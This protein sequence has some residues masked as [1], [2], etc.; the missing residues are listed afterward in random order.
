VYSC[1]VIENDIDIIEQLLPAVFQ[2][3]QVDETS[4][5]IVHRPSH[6][7]TTI[8]MNESRRWAPMNRRGVK[9]LIVVNYGRLL[10]MARQ[11]DH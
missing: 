3:R 6:D 2:K 4:R 11:M 5:L 7:P 10:I 1:E 9:V 8:M